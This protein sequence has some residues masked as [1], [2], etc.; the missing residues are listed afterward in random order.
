M[1]VRAHALY[2][3]TLS[4]SHPSAHLKPLPFLTP[5]LACSTDPHQASD[6]RFGPMIPI[7]KPSE[8]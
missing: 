4:P 3:H 7:M 8:G 5:V 6:R 1:Y 2:V